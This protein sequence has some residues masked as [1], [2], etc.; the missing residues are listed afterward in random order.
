MSDTKVR[1][2]ALVASLIGSSI[3]WFDFF[4]Y[5]SAAAL[6]FNKIFFSNIDSTTGLILSYLTFSLT[7]FVRPLGGVFF[8]HIGDRIGRKKTLIATLTLM[9]TATVCIGLL[10]GYDT[11]GIWSPLLLVFFRIMQGLGLG[12]E[13]GGALLLAYE[14]A[15]K[16]KRGFYGSVPQVGVTIGLLLASFSMAIM[17][18]VVSEEDFN[19][20]GWRVPF[21]ASIILVFLGLWIR[22]GIDET[23]AFKKAQAE[24]TVSKMPLKD[25][26]RYHWKE[27]IQAA[28]LKVAETGIFYIFAVFVVSY[29]TISLGYD[30]TTALNAV[31]VG[32]FVSSFCIPLGGMLSDKI[33]RIKTYVLGI[34]GMAAFIIPYFMLLDMKEPWAFILAS[35]VLFGIMWSPT[36]AT[37]GTL[38]SEIFAT[39]VR[40]T[41]ITLGYQLGA[42]IA[43]GTA[44]LIATWL[45]TNFNNSWVPIAIYVMALAACSMLAVFSLLKQKPKH[46][47]D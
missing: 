37:L 41:G 3:E 42:C 32:A 7:F 40:Y 28:G 1:R 38:S 16:E 27:V 9:G 22:K 23:P 4:L 35:F 2:K 8:A 39:N 34:I 46:M 6:V 13:W 10:P 36:T 18:N 12:G 31:I 15:P 20:W 45:L 47:D 29:S 43:G 25:T 19:A 26:L 24:G 44:P 30:R 17:T 5:G 21:V 33:G 14:Y 11:L